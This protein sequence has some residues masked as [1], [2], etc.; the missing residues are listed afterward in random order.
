MPVRPSTMTMNTSSRLANRCCS[1]QWSL[2]R[3]VL[4]TARATSG[5]ARVAPLEP[6][7][8]AI[9]GRHQHRPQ[10]AGRHHG[11]P[12]RRAELRA[13][14]GAVALTAE[15]GEEVGL[16]INLFWVIVSAINFLILFALVWSFAFKPL[17]KTL[18]DATGKPVNVKKGQWMH[19]EGMRG[20][21]CRR[22]AAFA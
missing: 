18:D 2:M 17:A 21:A 11:A 9:H 4:A 12:A 14:G 8:H 15:A 3:S 22:P 10:E 13:A 19:P 5:E 6:L 1:R 16:T 20:A 7:P